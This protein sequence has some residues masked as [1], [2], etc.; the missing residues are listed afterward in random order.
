MR[1]RKND[2]N[3]NFI[4]VVIIMWQP[5]VRSKFYSFLAFLFLFFIVVALHIPNQRIVKWKEIKNVRFFK[6]IYFFFTLMMTKFVYKI[7]EKK[8]L[9]YAGRCVYIKTLKY[10]LIRCRKGKMY[11]KQ[12][13]LQIRI[14]DLILW[15]SRRQII[16]IR[17]I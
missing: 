16:Y 10:L 7:K 12:Q 4:E 14:E 17:W 8:T 1:R 13:K 15:K 3:N 11:S 5:H 9:T 2:I 6:R